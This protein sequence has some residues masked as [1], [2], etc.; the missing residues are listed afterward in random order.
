MPRP[1]RPQAD[2]R[3]ASA[4]LPDPLHPNW[5]WR[6]C[7]V[8]LRNVFVFWLDYRA[9]GHQEL[10]PT[11]ALLVANHESFLDPFL[12]GLPLSRPISYLARHNLFSLPIVG[13]IL[14]T[15]YTMPINRDSA[16]SA[17]IREATRRMRHGFLVGIFPEGTRSNN[18]RLG[19]L[20]PGFIAL[21]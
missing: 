17:S 5:F 8:V 10:P 9:R 11:G 14:R 6:F 12:I 15:T 4:D 1:G 19:E 21:Q 2:E 16:S 18:S 3:P 20:K 13:T 7:R